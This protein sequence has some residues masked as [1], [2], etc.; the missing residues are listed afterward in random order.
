MEFSIEV[1]LYGTCNGRTDKGWCSVL[2]RSR[3]LSCYDVLFRL[4]LRE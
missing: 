4:L 2:S 3:P 1:Y